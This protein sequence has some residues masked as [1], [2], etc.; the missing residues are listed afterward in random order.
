M[1]ALL[2]AAVLMG[3]VRVCASTRIESERP[4]AMMPH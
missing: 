3:D 2:L 1:T 4:V